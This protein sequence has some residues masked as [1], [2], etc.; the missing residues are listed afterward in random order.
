MS[1]AVVYL[2]FYSFV[3][4]FLAT[5]MFFKCQF[6]KKIITS[7]SKPLALIMFFWNQKV[8]FF[9]LEHHCTH[10]PGVL[11]RCRWK[12]NSLKMTPRRHLA[13]LKCT[14]VMW[15]SNHAFPRFS[16]LFSFS[17]N[18]HFHR[19]IPECELFQAKAGRHPIVF[20]II[21]PNKLW[22]F[23]IFAQKEQ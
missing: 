3:L 1:I 12:I 17:L 7:V 11:R 16:I 14:L 5:F 21:I 10:P 20:M 2:M 15:N 9:T 8:S 23:P 4:V 19:K 6:K 18:K 22:T 13:S